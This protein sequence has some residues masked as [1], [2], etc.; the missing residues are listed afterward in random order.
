MQVANEISDSLKRLQIELPDTKIHFSAILPKFDPYYSKGI[1]FINR[2]VKA[3]CKDYGMGFIHHPE[4]HDAQGLLVEKLY[5]PS[6]WRL[7]KPLHPSHDGVSS[8]MKDFERH[9][10]R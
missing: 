3:L 2:Q 4:F 6:E 10:A 9:L 8:L 5:S 7:W 1:N